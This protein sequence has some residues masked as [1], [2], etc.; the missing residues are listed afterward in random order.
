MNKRWLLLTAACFSSL[1]SIAQG[2]N[3]VVN[4]VTTDGPGSSSNNIYYRPGDQL[5]WSDFKGKPVAGSDA[6]ALTNAG[7][8]V[9]LMFR[10]VE[11]NS[12]L[13]ISVNCVFSR[14]D[15]WV[16]P[17][18]KTAYIL[19][20]EQKHFDIAFIHTLQFIRN[21]RAAQFTNK[22]YAA[23]IEK[24][25]NESA[26][27]MSR[28]QGQYDAET[29]HSRIPDKQEAWDKVIAEQLEAALK[30]LKEG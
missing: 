30:A 18:N 10:R 24:I 12:Q 7:F 23:L 21:L 9:K 8:G 26:A 29:S 15:S 11:D 20:H 16:Q 6:A 2:L 14:K 19:N 27:A 4:Y 17:A 1:L 22:N 3:V 25:Y 5:G 28:V 13:V